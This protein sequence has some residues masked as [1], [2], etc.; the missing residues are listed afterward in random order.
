VLYTPDILRLAVESARF[1]RLDSSLAGL[2]EITE[3]AVPCGSAITLDL[4]LNEQGIVIATGFSLTACAFGQAS[5]TLFA[6]HAVG[7]T[8]PDFVRA[9]TSIS[10]WLHDDAASLPDWPGIAI[11]APAR[12]SSARHGAILLPFRAA[13]RCVAHIGG[14]D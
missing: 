2:V 13:M 4:A 10:D 8:G 3:R 12:A 14:A 6:R 7:R 5:A 9:A 11:L 1:S